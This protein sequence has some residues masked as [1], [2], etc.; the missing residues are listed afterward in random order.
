MITVLRATDNVR[1]F[2]QKDNDFIFRIGVFHQVHPKQTV[3]IP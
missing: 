2:S 3:Y 1:I